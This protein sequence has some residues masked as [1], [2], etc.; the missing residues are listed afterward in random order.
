MPQNYF[1]VL[2]TTS[3]PLAHFS[4]QGHPCQRGYDQ[5]YAIMDITLPS[6]GAVERELPVV[7][8]DVY[9]I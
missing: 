2:I 5:Q 3:P 8:A 1:S 4:K 6:Y 7:Q 9:K